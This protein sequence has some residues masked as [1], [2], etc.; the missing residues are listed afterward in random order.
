MQVNSNDFVMENVYFG[1][2]CY[3]LYQM[4]SLLFNEACKH[5]KNE[6]EERDN[7]GLRVYLGCYCCV[8]FLKSPKMKLLLA[9]KNVL[10]LGAGCGGLS[11]FAL[12]GVCNSMT[13]SDGN[14]SAVALAKMN[15]ELIK[16]TTK[17]QVVQL[18]WGAND[19]NFLQTY[20]DNNKFDVIIGSDLMYFSIDVLELLRTVLAHI[21]PI[22]GIFIHSHVFR[23]DGQ[24][25]EVIDIL[26]QY[27]WNSIEIPIETF[28]NLS[29]L[30]NH[31]DWYSTSCIIS[32]SNE[33]IEKLL[34]EN[35]D[36]ILFKEDELQ[37]ENF[38]F[39]DDF[40]A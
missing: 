9:H 6:K 19:D 31:P 2:E 27:K 1:N 7:T 24:K 30:S 21:D 3:Q 14:L 15:V 18:S 22:N 12:D 13:I 4:P 32:A 11:L 28:A 26:K 33:T 39:S 35:P 25:R 8:A 23:R 37:T 40:F 5:D 29:E 20:N 10:E 34:F 36:Y 16:Q 38:N 17:C